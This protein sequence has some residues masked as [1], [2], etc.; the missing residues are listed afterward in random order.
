[1]N[2]VEDSLDI[3]MNYTSKGEHVPEAERNNRTIG[4]RIRAT[5]HNLPYKAIPR[6]MLRYLSMV[7]T[8]QLNLFP[9]KGGVSAYLSPYTI[10]TGRNLDYDKH[11]QVPFGAYVQANQENDPTNTQAPRTIDAIY[12]RPMNNKQGGHELMNLRTGLMITRNKIH[13]RPL[14][15]LVIRAIETMAE[16]QGIKTLKLTGRNKTQLYPAD[17]IAGVEYEDEQNDENTTDNDDND[18]N[19]VDYQDRIPDY[20]QDDELD[21]QQEYESIDQDEIDDL[22]AEP[23]GT[24]IEVNP[25]EDQVQQEQVQQQPNEQDNTITDDEDNETV[26]TESSRPTR[27]RREPD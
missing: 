19:D 26:A 8:H 6:I 21:D 14:T 5:Y 20:T 23:G 13:E 2:E 18:D 15:D 4:E 12:L 24:N 1:M 17:W 16:Q 9:A 27:E 3:E 7:S 11:C 10:M 22:L 25:T